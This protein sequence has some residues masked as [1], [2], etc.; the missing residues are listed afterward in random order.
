MSKPTLWQRLRRAFGFAP[1]A[2]RSA[3]AGAVDSRL[4]DFV[5]SSI[6]S[7]KQETRYELTKLRARARDLARNNPN[8]RRFLRLLEQ[9]VV[10]HKGIRLECQMMLLTGP[11][12]GQP[13]ERANDLVESAWRDWGRVGN[14]DVTR[15]H[16]WVSL[17]KIAMRTAARDGE[18]FVR[19][20]DGFRNDY[21]FA[22]QLIDADHVDESFMGQAPTGNRIEQG[23]E[24]DRWGAPVAYYVW[25]THPAD[26][27][28]RDRQRERIPASEMIH[29]YLTEREGQARGVTWFAPV[30]VAMR[31]LDGYAEAELV[32]ARTSA[33]KMGFITRT[34][35]AAAPDPDLP[36]GQAGQTMDATPGVIDRLGVGESFVGWNPDHPAG[37]FEPFVLAQQRLMAMG[38]NVSH[39]SLTGDL[40]QANYSS[41][42]VGLLDE[43]DGWR[44]LQTWLAEHLHDRVYRRWLRMA[45]LSPRLKLPTYDL[46]KYE[47]VCWRPRGWD[48]VD[49]K[50]DIEAAGLA[51]DRGFKSRTEI[52]A[53]SGREIGDVLREIKTENALAETLDVPLLSGIEPEPPPATAPVPDEAAAEDRAAFLAVARSIDATGKWVAGREPPVPVVN[54]DARTTVEPAQVHIAPTEVRVEPAQVSVTAVIP[55][56]GVRKTEVLRDDD[57][58]VVGTLTSEVED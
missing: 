24:F 56:A 1:G 2:T 4:N 22:L 34:E 17:Q 45:S 37:N 19:L 42:R 12:A 20:V 50:N 53:E 33:A 49:P 52:V 16:S 5:F 28:N 6:Q 31:H 36:A 48:W 23:V 8:A 35:D 30:T 11:N 25:T 55:K 26:V 14:C 18:A 40:R 43:R 7:A 51:V 39:M 3:W 10:G 41:A 58:C 38:L 15:S 29:L 21:G 46:A 47:A 27:T 9:N 54:V 44:D 13:D 32:A 57:G